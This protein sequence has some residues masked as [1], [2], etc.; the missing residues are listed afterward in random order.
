MNDTLKSP[1]TL[2]GAALDVAKMPGHW[3][4][5]RLGKRV[6]RPGGLETTKALLNALSI[7]PQDDVVE[8]A[9]GLGG[10]ARLILECGPKSYVGL[11]RD[12][13]AANFT[14]KQLWDFP[15]A[16]V[17]VGAADASGLESGSACVVIGEA[18][19]TMN[20]E[21]HKE[22]I[23][24]EAFRLLKPGGRYGIHEL[25]IAPDTVSDAKRDEINRDLSAS[26]HVGARPLPSAGWRTSMEGAGFSVEAEGGA[27]MHLLRPKRMIEDEGVFGALNIAKNLVLNPAARKRVLAMR[28]VFETHKDNIAAIFVIARKPGKS[29]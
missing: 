15:D 26:I 17:Q 25:C 11:E 28:K 27:P 7:T 18:M 12:E 2:P 9:P 24:G 22:K 8:F 10:T 4:L 23:I 20:P 1:A 19:L 3:L 14:R 16:R 13:D 21:P 5:A 6:L 29:D